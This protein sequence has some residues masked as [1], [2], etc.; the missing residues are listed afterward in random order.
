MTCHG[1]VKSTS[2]KRLLSVMLALA[3]VKLAFAAADS[4]VQLVRNAA[5]PGPA[6]VV[7]IGASDGALATQLTSAGPWV[8]SAVARD[9][10]AA[11]RVR[12]ALRSAGVH[13]QATSMALEQR[14]LPLADWLAD[15]AVIEDASLVDATEVDRVVRPGGTVLT[16]A[17]GSLQRRVRARPAD[18]DSWP[19]YNHDA[20]G[21]NASRDRLAG[22][23]R[24]IRWISGP[25]HRSDSGTL[26]ADEFALVTTRTKAGRTETA[27]LVMRDAFNGLVLWERKDLWPVGRY[28]VVLT[29]ERLY[30]LPDYGDKGAVVEVL[31][32]AT[33]KTLQQFDQGLSL[34]DAAAR[35]AKV[36]GMDRQKTERALRE[37]LNQDRNAMLLLDDTGRHLLAVANDQ[38]VMVD[39]ATGK[40]LWAAAPAAPGSSIVWPVIADGLAIL[41]EGTP[42]DGLNYTH[43]PIVTV[44]RI[45]AYSLTDGKERWTW[46]WPEGRATGGLLNAVASSGRLAMNLRSPSERQPGGGLSGPERPQALAILDLASG[47]E[48]HWSTRTPF[49]NVAFGGHSGARIIALGDQLWKT[50]LGEVVGSVRIS[51]PNTLVVPA[52]KHGR[53]VACTS[54]RATPRWI[55]GN[56]A[57]YPVER[58]AGENPPIEY[59]GASRND[60]D[61]GS[62]PAN[63]LLYLTPNHCMC[64]PYLPGNIAFH[65]Q[66]PAAPDESGRLLRGSA[67]PAS[68]PVANG[69]PMLLR[70]PD[71][72]NWTDDALPRDLVKLWSV[73]PADAAP[74]A[75]IQ[76]QWDAHFYAQGP[77]T[78]VS[79]VGGVAVSAASHRQAIIACDAT[80]G[81]EL[82]RVP[83]DGR[84]DS[85]PT[86]AG[87]LVLAGTANGYVY[88]LNRDSGALVWRY[89]VAPR[90]DR[91][92][93]N[94]G[95]ES[96]WPVH[97]SVL[98]R[99]DQVIAIAGRHSEADGGMWW[100]V[101]DLVSGN[102]RKSGRVG[103]DAPL[104]T[105]NVYTT[106]WAPRGRHPE[107]AK[108]PRPVANNVPVLGG[109]KIIIPG[110]VLLSDG[111]NLTIENPAA[112]RVDAF[113]QGWDSTHVYP[114]NLGLLNRYLD[115]KGAMLMRYGGVSGR[116]FAVKGPE[117]VVVGSSITT[118]KTVAERAAIR[119]SGIANSARASQSSVAMASSTVRATPRS[120]GRGHATTR[121][122]SQPCWWPV[123][124][125]SWPGATPR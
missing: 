112:N 103:Q 120:S 44:T 38:A 68:K 49:L 20:A 90:R 17:N 65:S 31:D 75:Q 1:K 53:P 121:V 76:S 71:R 26:V 95:V 58:P 29:R 80:T 85:Q 125:S 11:D 84:V 14:R 98:V 109:S 46:S 118:Q 37:M 63:S 94:G 39:A 3:S 43:W 19:M 48:V 99:G 34:P 77:V 51:D 81:R 27:S 18:I 30:L 57:G 89:R 42:T 119:L 28:A 114:G 36:A 102:L 124:R 5:G 55:L 16:R 60:C 15:V 110:C 92:L 122:V 97:G 25:Q 117:F 23:G 40:R 116:L 69:W 24:G 4:D 32:P 13:G 86:I 6:L 66:M 108:L 113:R 93:V 70:S 52:Y 74:P 100:S 50:T 45:R 96:S 62:F 105:P 64:V 10:K 91:I 61:V 106:G 33:G 47:K 87:G 7:Q 79:V 67:A 111:D 88:A 56:L 101:L 104:V 82:W 78:G 123:T 72:S 59:Y 21:T 22:P 12:E 2:H 73:A 115:A 35:K 107:A 54:F 9:E 83:V 8:V 41:P